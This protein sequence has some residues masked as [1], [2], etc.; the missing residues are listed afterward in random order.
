MQTKVHTIQSTEN[1][2]GGNSN[3]TLD[4]QSCVWMLHWFSGFSHLDCNME[5]ASNRMCIPILSLPRKGDTISFE[6]GIIQSK[7]SISIKI[8]ISS[9]IWRSLSS[10]IFWTSKQNRMWIGLRLWSDWWGS[11]SPTNIIII[12]LWPL[13]L[14]MQEFSPRFEARSSSVRGSS[15]AIRSCWR[16]DSSQGAISCHCFKPCIILR[17]NIP[18]VIVHCVWNC[19]LEVGC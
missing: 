1:L 9:T 16:S 6:G 2:I 17:K 5:E 3:F 15:E 10:A 11:S 12:Y 7:N 18:M 13:H 8:Q 4:I 14:S 19:L